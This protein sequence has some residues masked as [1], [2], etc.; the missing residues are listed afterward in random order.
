MLERYL[1]RHCSPTLAALKTANLFSLFFS[2]EEELLQQLSA[3]NS[4]LE[5]KGVS[6]LLLCR[7]ERSALI[8]VYRRQR[9]QEE[10]SSPQTARFLAGCGY[11]ST[12]VDEA[13][14]RL[15]RR[16]SE[17]KT[18]PHEIGVFLGYPLGDVIGFIRNEGKNC[19]CADCWKVYG[20]EC[21]AKK[22]FA[23]FKRCIEVYVRLWKEGRSIRQLTVAA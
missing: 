4:C 13:I 11:E 16:L 9:L 20:D 6:L 2:S 5:D 17:K 7:R 14:L 1:I 22:T 21:E 10:L 3:W 15:Q 18:F 8:Y 23:K 12:D 19:K